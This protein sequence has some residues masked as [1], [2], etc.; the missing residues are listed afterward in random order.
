M[1]YNLF[2]TLCNIYIQNKKEITSLEKDV[3]WG[4]GSFVSA[5]LSSLLSFPSSEFLNNKR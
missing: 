1:P 4:E 3:S 2:A 5:F